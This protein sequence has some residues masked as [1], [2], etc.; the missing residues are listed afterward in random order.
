ME[1]EVTRQPKR[2][3]ID[4]AAS[5]LYF[6]EAKLT[7]L[8]ARLR[9]YA[10]EE[11]EPAEPEVG[12]PGVD[13]CWRRADGMEEVDLC[14]GCLARA[15]IYEELKAARVKRARRRRTWLGLMRRHVMDVET[16][17]SEAQG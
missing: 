9:E 14:Q 8:R 16:C 6:A 4:D 15:Q 10:C 7:E 17:A 13:T 2:D 3:Q 5:R 1:D 12:F 11:T